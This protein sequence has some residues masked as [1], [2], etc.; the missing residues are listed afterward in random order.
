MERNVRYYD[1]TDP[2]QAF[3]FVSVLLRLTQHG[4]KLRARFDENKGTFYDN[5]VK[6]RWSKFAQIEDGSSAAG[7][8]EA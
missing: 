3:Q 1:I 4:L 5:L 8:E 6:S 2:L 7:T